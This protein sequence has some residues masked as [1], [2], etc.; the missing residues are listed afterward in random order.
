ML[1]SKV[2]Y[3]FIYER[4]SIMGKTKRKSRD[5]KRTLVWPDDYKNVSSLIEKSPYGE[6]LRKAAF[7]DHMS[8]SEWVAGIIMD[9]LDRRYSKKKH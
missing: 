5:G 2:S 1:L 4:E 8:M 9:E 7:D 6:W 3:F